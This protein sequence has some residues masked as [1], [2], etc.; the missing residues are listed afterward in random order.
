MGNGI[1][2]GIPDGIAA[3][4]AANNAA[5]AGAFAPLLALGI[6]GSGTAAVLLSGLM[7][8]GLTPGPQLFT[9]EPEFCWGLIS[10]M[11]VGNILCLA[12]GMLMI[13]LLVRLISVPSKLISPVV[14]TL[15]FIGA[16][17]A[18]NEVN[19]LYVMLL[20]GLAGYF[21]NKY[22]YPTAPML[23][24]FVLTPTIEKNLY[25]T[26]MVNNGSL[27]IFWERPITLGLLIATA[28]LMV[29]PVVLKAVRKGKKAEAQQ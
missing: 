5:A 8:W 27:S 7:M 16:F 2:S 3:S 21:M 15:C 22:D 1:P 11:Y 12:M 28:A 26:L 10:S 6:P 20:G 4:E 14:V 25:R 19:N 23:L 24:A 17:A 13:P 29:A 18:S 9:D